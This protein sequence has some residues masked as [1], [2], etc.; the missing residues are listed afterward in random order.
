MLVLRSVLCAV[1]IMVFVSSPVATAAFIY[2]NYNGVSVIYQAVTEDSLTDPGVQLFGA[3][4]VSQDALVFS[5]VSFGA[6]ASGAGASD[7]TDGT[8]AGTIVAKPNK[9]IEKVLFSE[10]GDWTLAGG[11]GTA[12]TN[13]WVAASL[14]VRVLEIDGVG[15]N[16]IQLNTNFTFS[17]SDGTYN[18]VDD[19]G[20]AQI[21]NGGVE[22][23]VSAMIAAAGK[24]GKATKVTISLDNQLY[25]ASEAG[26]IA[27]IKKKTV[28]GVTI[29][30]IV[31]EPMSLCLLALGALAIARRRDA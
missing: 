7:F 8:L 22:V 5:P 21:W 10:S 9:V 18:L 6:F 27:H 3:P 30:A 31:P 12:A 26:T 2:G 17:P 16:P 11:V 23:D 13:A 1:G 24:T 14:F 28:D 20:N 15:V 4:S 25:A 19:R 29:T